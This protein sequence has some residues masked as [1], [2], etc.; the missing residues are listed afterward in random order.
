MSVDN[1][2]VVQC[3]NL[4]KSKDPAIM[5]LIRALY[6]YTSIYHVNYKSVHLYSVDNGSAHAL[7]RL[8]FVQFQALNPLTNQLMTPLGECIIDFQHIFLTSLSLT[9]QKLM[10]DGLRLSTTQTYSSAQRSFISFCNTF[11]LAPI[12]GSEQTILWYID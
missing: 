5:G 4:G 6:Y 9:V 10:L 11:Y 12:P 1:M 7:T 3:I 8:Q 2:G